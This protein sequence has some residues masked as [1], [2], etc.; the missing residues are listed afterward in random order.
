MIL[1]KNEDRDKY[2]FSPL[3]SESRMVEARNK[4]KKEYHPGVLS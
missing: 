1:L 2:F 4:E 3:Y